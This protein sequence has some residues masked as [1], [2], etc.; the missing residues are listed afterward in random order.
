MQ[1]HE[2][3]DD[4]AAYYDWENAQPVGRRYIAFWSE[5]A[6]RVSTGVPGPCEVLAPPWWAKAGVK[7]ASSIRK[8]SLTKNLTC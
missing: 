2:G 7:M 1:G 4:Y 8:S 6:R 3:W 5:F